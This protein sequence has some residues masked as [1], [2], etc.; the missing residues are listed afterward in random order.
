MTSAEALFRGKVECRFKPHDAGCGQAIFDFA[1]WPFS[2]YVPLDSRLGPL[3]I[4]GSLIRYP[5]A[6]IS[7]DGRCGCGFELE[8]IPA[9]SPVGDVL[10]FRHVSPRFIP[11]VVGRRRD[12]LV[13]PKR[14][15]SAT[16]R[17]PSVHETTVTIATSGDTSPTSQ[18]LDETS[19]WCIIASSR[20]LRPVPATRSQPDFTLTAEA[21]VIETLVARKAEEA[22]D[23]I[24]RA[25]SEVCRLLGMEI[26][27]ELAVLVRRGPS[28]YRVWDQESPGVIFIDHYDLEAGEPYLLCYETARQAATLAWGTACQLHGSRSV[29]LEEAMGTAVAIRA[30]DIVTATDRS[31]KM[32]NRLRAKA[33]LSASSQP[34]EALVG[35]RQRRAVF[36]FANRLLEIALTRGD[37]VFRK[38][39]SECWGLSTR[40]DLL[41]KAADSFGQ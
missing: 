15:F 13:L 29:E 34:W 26:H 31:S 21:Q 35:E 5:L 39:T 8:W 7:G 4:R 38:L 33:L 24:V 16:P 40:V 14:H 22:F 18:R 20:S 27:Q 17:V 41:L 28:T 10:G 23:L 30:A 37:G 6:P 3:E 9:S 19:T 32:L 2:A 12:T 11:S 36:R 1:S 25:C